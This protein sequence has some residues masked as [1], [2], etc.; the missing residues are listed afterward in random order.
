M[1]TTPPQLAQ[2]SHPQTAFSQSPHLGQ[3]SMSNQNN[4]D[5]VQPRTQ[6]QRNPPQPMDYLP[7]MQQLYNQSQRRQAAHLN[8][9]PQLQQSDSQNQLHLQAQ[10]QPQGY[11]R[12]QVNGIKR[13]APPG[14]LTLPPNE[15]TQQANNSNSPQTNGIQGGPVNGT[16][17]NDG[18][19][20]MGRLPSSKRARTNSES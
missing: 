17:M 15:L 3:S 1:N 5:H 11:P 2:Q 19:Q 16:Q 18:S 7:T 9:H 10:G 20:A 12:A 14:T 6:T 13:K 8:Q 4:L